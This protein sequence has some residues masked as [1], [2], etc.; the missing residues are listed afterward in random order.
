MIID[1]KEVIDIIGTAELETLKK[2]DSEYTK[3]IISFFSQVLIQKFEDYAEKEMFQIAKD[4]K[5]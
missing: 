3:S 5:Q 1:H 2:I 4:N